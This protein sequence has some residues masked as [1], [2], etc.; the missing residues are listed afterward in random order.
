M[1]RGLVLWRGGLSP[2]GLRSS[3]KKAFPFVQSNR[4]A[5]LRAAAQPNGEQAPS[6]LDKP[7]RH[8]VF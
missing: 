2:V 3:P 8:K 6:P 4:G 7:T 1:E 5:G